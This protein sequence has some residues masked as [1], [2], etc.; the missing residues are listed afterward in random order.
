MQYKMDLTSLKKGGMTMQEYLL[1][2]KGL[3]TALGFADYIMSVNDYIMH[4]LYG[5]GSDYDPLIC[6]DSKC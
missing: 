1:K 4:I 6:N 3:V 5:L 2:V